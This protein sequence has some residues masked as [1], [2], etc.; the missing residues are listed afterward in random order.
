M[1]EHEITERLRSM[2]DE[3]VPAEARTEHLRRIA[4]TPVEPGRAFGRVWV[5]AAAIV[6]FLVGSTGLAAAGALPDPAQDVAHDVLSVVQID[7]PEGKRGPCVSAIAKSDLPKAEKKAAKDACPKG[8][9]GGTGGDVDDDGEPGKSGEAPGQTKHADDPCKGKPP[10]AGQKGLST[11]EKDAMKA[12]RAATCGRDLDDDTD[13]DLD[14]DEVEDA[15]VED[16]EPAPTREA[17]TTTTAAP[18][19]TTAP[20][21][22]LAPTTTVD[23]ATTTTTTTP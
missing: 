14:E 19:I 6:G 2:G 9:N 1:D 12:E 16:D 15:E 7:V 20:S 22:T 23:D 13:D 18:T 11:A 17:V 5:A 8:G 4:A 21:T 3:P 10:W